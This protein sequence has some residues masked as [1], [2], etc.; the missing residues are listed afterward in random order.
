MVVA[1]YDDDR[2]LDSSMKKADMRMFAHTSGYETH[3]SGDYSPITIVGRTP[4]GHDGAVKHEFVAFH[5]ELMGAR[6]EV[7]R[8]V[9]RERLGYVSSEQE[10]RAPRR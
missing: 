2:K 10:A 6:D 3:Q 9:V 1:V 5:G 7:N 4:H 8:I